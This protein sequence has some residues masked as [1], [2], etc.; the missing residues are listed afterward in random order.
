MDAV[1]V[2][3]GDDSIDDEA[4]DS[5]LEEEEL[6][7][8]NDCLSDTTEDKHRCKVVLLVLAKNVNL[9]SPGGK[10][11]FREFWHLA[12]R[13]STWSLGLRYLKNFWQA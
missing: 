8:L 12:I 6:L 11:Q 3:V 4:N 10:R 5:I 7:E 1:L 2:D 13:R 9:S